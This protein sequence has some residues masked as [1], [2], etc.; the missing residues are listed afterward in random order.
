MTF[1]LIPG[2]GG[3]GW[4]WHRL[5]PAL[6]T[7]GHRAVPIT[8][9]AADEAKGLAEY[10]DAVVDQVDGRS[11]RPVTLVA[12]SL[13]AFTV[14]YVAPRLD[15]RGVVLVNAMVPLPGETAGEWWENTGQ[16]SAR[17]ALAV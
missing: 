8:L 5:V 14:P 10:A 16:A 12:H 7:R 3:S 2:A 4:L 11:G 6:A 17:L 1:V 13:G 15:V 9:P